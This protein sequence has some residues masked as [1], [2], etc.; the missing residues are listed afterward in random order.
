[1]EPM[2]FGL[3]PDSPGGKGGGKERTEPD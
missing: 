3:F 1:M 2:I